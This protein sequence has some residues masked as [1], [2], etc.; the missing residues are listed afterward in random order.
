MIPDPGPDGPLPNVTDLVAVMD[1]LRS[2]GGCPW[3]A[4]QTPASLVQ[5]A[6]EEVYEVAEAVETGDRELLLEELGDLLLQVVF[7]ARVAQEHP[8]EP[9]DLEDVAAGIAAKLRRRHPHVFAGVEVRDA[10]EVHRR[11]EQIKAAEKVDR[12]S[13]LDGVPLALPA[14]QRAQKVVGRARRAG[15]PLPPHGEVLDEAGLG[16]ALLAL[17][18]AA[19]EAGLDAEAALRSTLRDYEVQARAAESN[20]GSTSTP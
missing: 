13:V 6:V 7:Q 18:A 8:T 16:S 15:L 10:D 12:T 20:G 19:Q 11:W 9:F 2:P 3:D 1:R 5:Y 4:E 17:V 14:L